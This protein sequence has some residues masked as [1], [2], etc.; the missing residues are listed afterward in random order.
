MYGVGTVLLLAS[1]GWM[2]ICFL[3]REYNKNR[4]LAKV[5]SVLNVICYLEAGF[6]IILWMI[7]QLAA[8]IYYSKS[9]SAGGAVGTFLAT[10]TV[11]FILD[12]WSTIHGVRVHRGIFLV[13]I[14]VV[15]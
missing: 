2:L 15:K 5:T 10:A 4:N 9:I 1:G 13:P 11:M 3:L 6:S 14:I 7:V 12:M 8:W